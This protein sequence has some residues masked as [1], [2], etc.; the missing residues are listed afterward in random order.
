MRVAGTLE[1]N[2]S[3]RDSIFKQCWD[4]FLN[5]NVL[6]MLFGHG[7]SATVG[8]IGIAAH[9]DWLE[10]LVNQGLLGVTVYLFFWIAFYKTFRLDNSRETKPVIGSVMLIYFAATLF[11][12]S[13]SAM[14]LPSTLAL[15]YC[16]AR[17]QQDKRA[18]LIS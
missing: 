11:S 7:A 9:N 14:T 10:I 15:G 8:I 5:S 1:G 17:Q 4:I 6:G 16:L 12:M 18:S 2:S 3:G 13:Y